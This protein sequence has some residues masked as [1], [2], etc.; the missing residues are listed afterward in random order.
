MPLDYSKISLTAKLTAYMRQFTD[1]PFARDVS[2][3]VHAKQAVE[4]LLRDQHIKV[5]ALLWYAP[6]LEARY[7]SISQMI[8]GSGVRQVL[9]LAGG[10][11]LRGLALGADS[12]LNYVDTDLPEITVEKAALIADISRRHHLP[13]QHN[14]RLVAAN[15]LEPADLAFAAGSFRPGQPVAVVHEG[16]LQY[17]TS[18]E[19]ETIAVNIRALLEKFGGVWITPDFSLKADGANVSPEQ[20]QFREIVAATTGRTMYNNA[21]DSAEH[22]TDYFRPLGFQVEVYNQL[23]LAPV[24]SSIDRVDPGQLEEFKPRLRLWVLRLDGSGLPQ[25]R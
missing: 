3:F 21:F 10:L 20:R 15:A 13:A 11:S 25:S 17:L 6:I 22:L 8:L 14:L 23:Y 2:E 18:T 16:L 19:T 5:E 4:A 24:L 7:K 9:E 1:I 12:T